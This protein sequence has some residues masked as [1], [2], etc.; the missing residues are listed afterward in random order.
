MVIVPL[1]SEDTGFICTISW[2]TLEFLLILL[3]RCKV[4]MDCLTPTTKGTLAFE[5]TNSM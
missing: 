1:I 2:E 4:E 5:P 3:V